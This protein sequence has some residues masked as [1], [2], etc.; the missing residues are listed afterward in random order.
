MKKILIPAAMY[1]FLLICC[2]AMAQSV[3]DPAAFLSRDGVLY[4]QNTDYNGVSYSAYIFERPSSEQEFLNDYINTAVNAGYTVGKTQVEGYPALSIGAQFHEHPALLLYNYQENM[5]LLVPTDM[6][7][8]LQGTGSKPAIDPLYLDMIS[9]VTRYLGETK[10]K[11]IGSDEVEYGLSPAF[12]EAYYDRQK[13]QDFGYC[14][15]DINGDG[16]DEM[17]FGAMKNDGY[18]KG[19][20]IYDLFTTRNGKLVHLASGFYRMNY[21]LCSDGELVYRGSGSAFDGQTVYYRLGNGELV[22]DRNIYYVTNPDMN[23]G[24]YYISNTSDDYVF[25]DDPIH[26]SDAEMI[27]EAEALRIDERCGQVTLQL[28]PFF[29]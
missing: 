12:E 23:S 13:V 18:S 15:T 14:F 25:W 5:L 24:D 9:Y 6:Y 27:T 21:H 2:T 28:Q 4:E 3:P 16:T 11:A 1:L 19:T 17:I 8:V 10:S 7:F 20:E 29:R 22:L 26:P